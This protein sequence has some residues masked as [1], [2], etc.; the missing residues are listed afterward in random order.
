MES[1]CTTLPTTTSEDVT[2]DG[3]EPT[4]NNVIIWPPNNFWLQANT[5][6]RDDLGAEDANKPPLILGQMTELRRSLKAKF[7]DSGLVQ[8]FTFGK[9]ETRCVATFGLAPHVRKEL[10][11]EVR[12]MGWFCFMFHVRRDPE[13]DN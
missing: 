6:G 8:T 2:T 12:Q 4:A 9:D 5:L 10:I 1:F 7:P 11:A 3:W 13:P